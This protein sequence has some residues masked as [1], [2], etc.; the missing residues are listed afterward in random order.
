VIA[1]PVRGSFRDPSGFVFTSNGTLYRQVN[2]VFAEEYDACVSSG[3]YDDLAAGRLLVAHRDV[4]VSYAAASDAHTVI[5]P[6]RIPFVSYPYEWSFGQLRDAALLTLE[7]QER[8][9]ERGF[10]LRDASAYNVQFR[11]GVPVFIDTLSFERYHDG[12]PWVAYKQFCEHFLVPLALMS[13]TDIRCGRLQREYLDGIPLDLGSALLPRR[14]WVNLGMLLHVHLHARAMRRYAST[15]VSQVTGA[16]TLSKR[17]LTGLI[18]SLHDVVKGLDWRPAGT[19]WADYTSDNN[20]T[21]QSIDAKRQLVRQYVKA[22]APRTVW[23]LGG[24]TGM[25]SRVAR[26]VA[27]SVVCFDFDPAAVELNYR[28]VR[29]RN[30]T[31]LLP[32]QLDLMNPSPANGWAHEERHSLEQRG[33]ADLVM[34]LALVHHLAIASNIPLAR[35]AEYFARL[36][37]SLVIEFVPKSDSQVVRLLTNRADIFPDYAIEGF[38]RA[39]EPWFTTESKQR[40]GDS[41]RTLYLMRRREG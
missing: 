26:E 23:D 29:A 11:D 30:E 18:T 24:N 27:E 1:E 5:E 34:A 7:I 28:E 2:R 36:G 22:V 41:E 12:R 25:F 21:D 31:G 32:L 40:V 15:S 6:A 33:P 17:A 8:A 37:R 39:F 4:G 9:L 20:Y 3:L 19:T 10:V 16:R 35:C 13:A 38:E 14:S